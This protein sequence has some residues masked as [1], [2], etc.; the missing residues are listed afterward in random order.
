M[1]PLDPVFEI[2]AA[3]N[4]TPRLV[5]TWNTTVPRTP[6]VMV[7]IQLDALVV[8]QAGG[9]WANC[10]MS[11]PPDPPPNSPPDATVPRLSLL[12]PPFQELAAESRPP[13]VYL[14]WALPDGL[15]RA[16]I[17]GPS[18]PGTTPDPTTQAEFPQ[19]PDRWLVVRMFPSPQLG[20][21]RTIQGWVL[22]AGEK[23]PI[24]VSLDQWNE[25]GTVLDT[26]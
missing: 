22:R 19:I 17:P 7:P 23:A 21:R 12:P 5:A 25:P 13:G 6:R 9:T 3:H 11:A 4:I 20:P 10:L 16:T 18:D 14:H 1:A 24:K 8:R 2:A 26:K 15:T